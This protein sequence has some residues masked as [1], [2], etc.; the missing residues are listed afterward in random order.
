MKRLFSALAIL[1]TSF[2]TLGQ[3]NAISLQIGYYQPQY[4]ALSTSAFYDVVDVSVA[5][6]KFLDGVEKHWSPVA[7]LYHGQEYFSAQQFYANSSISPYYGFIRDPAV[8]S[9]ESTI[10]VNNILQIGLGVQ[11]AQRLTTVRGKY[12]IDLVAQLLANGESNVSSDSSPI[13][14]LGY[15]SLLGA[16]IGLSPHFFVGVHGGYSQHWF[17]GEDRAGAHRV[18]VPARI[19]ATYAF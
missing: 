3:E 16:R 8:P 11:F 7:R 15:E 19:S 6:A 12:P 14:A 2:S 4:S 10:Y 9:S 17:M 5:Y 13:Y 18:G 1:A